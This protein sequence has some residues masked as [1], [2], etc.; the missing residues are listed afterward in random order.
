MNETDASIKVESMNLPEFLNT[1]EKWFAVVE[2]IDTAKKFGD[3]ALKVVDDDDI[4]VFE[5]RDI[6]T[7][8]ANDAKD[9]RPNDGE[10]IT[11]LTDTII[12]LIDYLVRKSEESF[13][14]L[15]N[16]MAELDERLS[17]IG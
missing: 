4:D 6:M 1:S 2:S 9:C 3:T 17:N 10:F 16:K 7:Q 11:S 13:I 5:F 8:L 12:D 15:I 14:N